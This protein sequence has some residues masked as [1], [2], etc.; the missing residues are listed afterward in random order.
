MVIEQELQ[1]LKGFSLTCTQSPLQE[2]ARL[3]KDGLSLRRSSS[4]FSRRICSTSSS[5]IKQPIQDRKVGNL[6]QRSSSMTRS[7]CCRLHDSKHAHQAT[8]LPGWLIERRSK[9]ESIQLPNGVQRDYD[10]T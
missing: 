4:W 10:H 8:L 2:L 1:G 3:D 6:R 5:S 9:A 7:M